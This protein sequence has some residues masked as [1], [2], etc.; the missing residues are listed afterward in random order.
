MSRHTQIDKIK[1][2]YTQDKIEVTLVEE[3]MTKNLVTHIL[4]STQSNFIDHF[5]FFNKTR[6][7]DTSQH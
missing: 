5:L 4:Y 3:K 6:R 7:V 2:K 1:N